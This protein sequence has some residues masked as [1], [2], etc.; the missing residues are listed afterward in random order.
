VL[1]LLFVTFTQVSATLLDLGEWAQVHTGVCLLG[2]A[3]CA[4]THADLLR[5]AFGVLLPTL[6]AWCSTGRDAAIPHHRLKVVF[7]G[8]EKWLRVL[9]GVTPAHNFL[10]IYTAAHLIRRTQHVR[11]GA[12]PRSSATI[13]AGLPFTRPRASPT[14]HAGAHHHPLLLL[15]GPYSVFFCTLHTQI[16]LGQEW[17]GCVNPL[18]DN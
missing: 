15:D 4:D 3:N 10:S 2:L 18:G 1:F 7:G 14:A 11:W 5:S 13:L 12:L 9:L 17:C 16:A 8:D 6:Q